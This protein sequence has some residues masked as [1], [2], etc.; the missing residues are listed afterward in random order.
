M[1]RV[2]TTKNLFARFLKHEKYTKRE[3]KKLNIY[4]S[5]LTYK[6]HGYTR[7]VFTIYETFRPDF[8]VILKLSLQ[9]F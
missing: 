4:N 9:N 6:T 7:F 5:T 8:L 3:K 1:R 2:Q